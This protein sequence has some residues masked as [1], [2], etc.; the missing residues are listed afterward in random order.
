MPILDRR[1]F[2][3]TSAGALAASALR[4]AA[5]AVPE[6]NGRTWR[7]DG[8]RVNQRLAS[9]SRFGA[10]AQGGV[11]RT[12]FS[13]A[14]V[15]GRAFV[16]EMM[17]TAGL[18]VRVDPVGNILGRR[19]GLMA[20]AAPILF[21]SHIDSV[22]EG[23]NYDGDVGSLSAIEV[24]QVLREKGYRNRRPL[25][26]AIWCDEESGLTGSRGFVGDL[27][28]ADLVRPSRNGTPLAENIR[29]LGG[30]PARLAE[31]HH[32]RGSVAAYV[33]LHIEQGG[34][35]DAA[36]VPIG[37][38]EGIVGIHHYEVTVRGFANH[39]GTTPMDRRRNAL[40]AASEIVLAVERVVRSV[41]GRQVGTVGR[42]VVRPGAPNVIPGEVSFT[43][44]LRDL[45]TETID[46]LWSRLEPEARALAE[47]QGCTMEYVL[48][49]PDRP[50][51]SDP[52]M[53]DLIRSVADD[54]G[55]RHQDLPSGAGHDAQELARI[56]PMGMIFIPSVGGISHS[57]KELSRPED[58]ANGANVLLQT[59]LRLDQGALDAA[60]RGAAPR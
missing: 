17:R 4:R 14:D 2:V 8:A 29:R 12:A 26:V 15:E 34:T 33:E 54:L 48:A 9:L 7:V 1:T 59:V 41:P 20:E 19:A 39:A 56:A 58:I 28:A 21:G 40:L 10:N 32:A 36:G 55:L 43:I 49:P 60:G 30:D 47:R 27:A 38:V 11:S 5:A 3:R 42:L 37:V 6:A 46:S 51:L 13:P 16:M 45:K 22:P 44:E 18:E 52:R 25:E 57:P 23:G 35:L 53:R 24:A 31:A 50:A